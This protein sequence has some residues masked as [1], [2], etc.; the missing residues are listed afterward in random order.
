MI[1]TQGANI[2]E[3]FG[4]SK[5]PTAGGGQN[6]GEWVEWKRGHFHQKSSWQMILCLL[7]R[8]NYFIFLHFQSALCT[9]LT[10]IPRF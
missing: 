9:N 7:N 6:G 8:R 3:N 2:R 4:K 5:R 10:K 1:E